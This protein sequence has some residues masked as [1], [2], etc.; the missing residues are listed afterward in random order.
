MAFLL[1]KLPDTLGHVRIVINRG[2]ENGIILVV[3]LLIFCDTPN[4]Q[5]L[6]A[7]NLRVNEP[8]SYL[9]FC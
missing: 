6:V 1:E 4:I 3:R 9:S 5:I 8:M 7:Q 2:G